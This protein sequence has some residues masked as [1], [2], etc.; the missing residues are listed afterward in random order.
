MIQHPSLWRS[1]INSEM[2]IIVIVCLALASGMIVAIIKGKGAVGEWLV[3]LLLKY[4]LNDRDYHLIRDVTLNIGGDSTQIDHVV[5]STFGIFVIETKNY[6]GWI[7]G[8]ESQKSWTQ[9]L[10]KKSFNFQN[11]LHQNYKHVTFL[12]NLL[13]LEP[14]H[15]HSLVVFVGD[16]E[17]KTLMPSNVVRVA[18]MLSYIKS[19]KA[20]KFD[21][22]R[23]Q[24]LTVI[25][26]NSRQ[27][28]GSATNNMHKANVI[29][30]K[31]KKSPF[32]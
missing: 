31:K 4:G 23:V 16:A 8:S 17:F 19:F 9:K 29:A 28:P 1:L 6:K 25:I 32:S 5:V 27:H 24:Q 14:E 10:Y 2:F 26:E 21:H 12:R 13:K 7:F 20:I 3:N 18:K 30:I 15:F 11:P 22:S